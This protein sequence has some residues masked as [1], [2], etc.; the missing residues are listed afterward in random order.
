[1]VRA[2]LTIV[3][4]AG[5]SPGVVEH[6]RSVDGVQ[7]ADIVAGEFDIVAQVTADSEQDLLHLVT[8]DVQSIDGV[9]RTSTCIVLE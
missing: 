4:N 1:M 9:G 6:L 7:Q 8:R 2:Y 5:D 3:T